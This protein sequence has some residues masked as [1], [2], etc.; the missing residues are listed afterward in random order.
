M[1]LTP[2]EIEKAAN[3]LFVQIKKYAFGEQSG[4]SAAPTPPCIPQAPIKSIY[5][6]GEATTYQHTFEQTGP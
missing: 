6:N 2:E 1:P 3:E 4:S 5:G